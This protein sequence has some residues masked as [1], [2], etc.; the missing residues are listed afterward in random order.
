MKTPTIFLNELSLT[1]D[2]ELEPQELLPHVLATL[3]TAREAKKLRRELIV[4]GGLAQVAF[5]VGSHTLP[6]LLRGAD[7][8][9]EWQSLKG[10][11]QI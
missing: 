3:K 10:L 4:V 5:G 8:R 7:Y 2:R 9:E 11:D 6:S 1:A